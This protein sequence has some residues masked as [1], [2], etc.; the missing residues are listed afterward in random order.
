[1]NYSNG[2][3]Y[4]GNYACGQKECDGVYLHQDA[5]SAYQGAFKLDKPEGVGVFQY[6]NGDVYEG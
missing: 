1:M 4:E 6:K 3:I 5:N 2:D